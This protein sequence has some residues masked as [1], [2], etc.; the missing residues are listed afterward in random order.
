MV[1]GVPSRLRSYLRQQLEKSKRFTFHHTSTSTKTKAINDSSSPIP[2]TTVTSKPDV[3]TPRIRYDEQRNSFF[4]QKLPFEIRTMIYAYIWQGD[5][6]HMYHESNGRHLHFQNGHWIS[7]RCV[8]YQE[9]DEDLDMIQKQMDIIQRSGHGDLLLW[10]R[11]LASTWGQRHWRCGE[12]IEY[13]RPTSIDRTDLGALMVTC[14]K[15]DVLLTFILRTK[16]SGSGPVFPGM[17]QDY[18]QRPLLG[19]PV[20]SAVWAS[21]FSHSAPPESRAHV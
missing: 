17:P 7:T 12:R 2:V 11:R 10:Q 1:V 19:P 15:I 8:M 3:P 21:L 13:G 20:P 18:I 16:A 6:D 14:K 4:F 5:Y 9:D